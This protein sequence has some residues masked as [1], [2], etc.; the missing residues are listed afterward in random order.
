MFIDYFLNSFIPCIGL[1]LGIAIYLNKGGRKRWNLKKNVI[2]KAILFGIILSATISQ[3]R[4]FNNNSYDPLGKV[5]TNKDLPSFSK[6]EK[7]LKVL[8]LSFFNPN[9]QNGSE[10]VGE[11]IYL[12][13]KGINKSD[14][15]NLVVLYDNT[16]ILPEDDMGIKEFQ[17]RNNADILIYGLSVQKDDFCNNIDVCVNYTLS[18]QIFQNINESFPKDKSDIEFT[19]SSTK[20]ILQGHISNEINSILLW[21]KALSFSKAGKPKE[22][23]PYL[24]KLINVYKSKNN[25]IIKLLIHNYVFSKEIIKADSL[26]NNSTLDKNDY[27]YIFYEAL[28]LKE[29]GELKKALT[30]F[31]HLV[32]NDPSNRI[33]YSF[34]RANVA[35][36]TK[37]FHK[38]TKDY[39]FL[40]N[41]GFKK[42][43]LDRATSYSELGDYENSIKD[44]NNHLL[45]A[46]SK[47]DSIGN[48]IYRVMVD[49]KFRKYSDLITDYE[50]L[51]SL[52]IDDLIDPYD[53]SVLYFHNRN[54]DKALEFLNV[55]YNQNPNDLKISNLRNEILKLKDEG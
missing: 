4:I 53:L 46:K 21:V 47:S 8:V 29:N 38:A 1:C 7:K 15:L 25:D 37:D 31:D 18:E 19:N 27:D 48:Y 36:S 26:L 44:L 41:R 45:L 49:S 42:Y 6:S 55:A 33:K 17:I 50:I 32:I 3:I 34:Y 43:M 22:S 14:S 12:G 51:N 24:E 13:L 20:N 40:I 10:C 23:I 9:Y 39:S 11:S 5:E 52:G 30:K 54:Y 35:E 28:I 16:S 2:F